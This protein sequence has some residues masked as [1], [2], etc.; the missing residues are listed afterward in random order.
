MAQIVT[1]PVNPI[2]STTTTAPRGPI[3]RLSVRFGGKNPKEL[4]RFL[5]FAVVGIIGAVIDL[6]TTNVLL[7][8][9]LRP[10]SPS[11]VTPSSIAAATGFTLA[12]ISNFIWNRYW[13]YPD[14]R[15]RP[16]VRQLVQ[17]FAVNAV[18][19]GIRI[20]ILHVMQPLFGTLIVNLIPSLGDKLVTTLAANG[21]VLV[22]LVVVMLWNFFVNRRWTYS[23]V[24]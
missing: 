3:Q 9:L 8:T 7:Q 16:I 21:A 1:Q 24:K 18:G 6:T 15:S 20:V 11:D 22:A 5:K 12:V 23:D 14:S 4:E 2:D 19:F 13:T 17:F 10:S